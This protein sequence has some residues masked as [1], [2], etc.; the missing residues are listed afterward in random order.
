MANEQK[1]F[2]E[3]K[4]ML[5]VKQGENLELKTFL[6]RTTKVMRDKKEKKYCE[7]KCIGELGQMKR[8]ETTQSW[9]TRNEKLISLHRRNAMLRKRFE[10]EFMHLNV[11]LQVI[12]I[13]FSGIYR[14]NSTN[15]NNNEN[16]TT[17]I[18]KEK[19]NDEIIEFWRKAHKNKIPACDEKNE[20]LW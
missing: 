10:Y 5:C 20:S 13:L 17:T 14:I 18:N 7:G 15:N 16:N 4:K 8:W 6:K 12:I 3:A 2:A 11:F 9:K 1:I 19:T